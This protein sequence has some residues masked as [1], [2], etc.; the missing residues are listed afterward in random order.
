MLVVGAVAVAALLIVVL[1]ASLGG[2]GGG[3]TTP[4]VPVTSSAAER[5][6]ASNAPSPPWLL[7]EVLGLDVWNSSTLPLNTSSIPSNCTVSPPPELL[8]S[9]ITIPSFRGNISA[10]A[11]VFWIL[12]YVQPSTNSSMAVLVV[13]G[14]AQPLYTLSG[15]ACVTVSAGFTGL[16]ANLVDSGVAAQAIDQDGGAQYLDAHRAGTSLEMLLFPP[17]ESAAP[18]WPTW[19][20]VYTP[21]APLGLAP[22]GPTSALN[23]VASVNATTG[24]VVNASAVNIDCQQNL[25]SPPP[26]IFSALSPG[27]PQLIRGPGTGGTIASQGC[28]SGDYCYELPVGNATGEVTPA[29]FELSVSNQSGPSSVP[30]GYAVLNPQGQVIV[31]SLGAKESTWT[32]DAGSASTPIYPGSSIWVD[33]GTVDPYGQNYYLNIQGEGPYMD[34]G[35]VFSLP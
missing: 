11:A 16:P 28:A 29:D 13:N 18:T 30:V 22:A 35:G 32:P 5:A 24:A 15:A 4:G 20:F 12:G 7:E 14:V 25:T 3:A 8:P 10:G 1:A 21:C 17:F 27:L 31:Y 9:S 26:S 23:F 34:S 2:S 33:M 19:D 6:G